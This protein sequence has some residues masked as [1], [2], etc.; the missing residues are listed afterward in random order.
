LR[1]ALVTDA[2]GFQ[3]GSL[4]AVLW[5][6]RARWR[7]KG[8]SARHDRRKPS[9]ALHRPFHD[10][11]VANEQAAEEL[12]WRATAIDRYLK[13]KLPGS[14]LNF[15]DAFAAFRDWERQNPEAASNFIQELPE[16]AVVEFAKNPGT[17]NFVRDLAF[18]YFRPE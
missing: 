4:H 14:Q 9:T 13:L 1:G 8:N 5:E 6:R 16:A 2:P 17:A 12:R 18:A 3:R 10:W 7:T 15:V 11:I